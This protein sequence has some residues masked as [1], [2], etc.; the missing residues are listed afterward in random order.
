MKTK[1][2]LLLLALQ[3]ACMS[4]AALPTVP[5]D[6]ELKRA[7]AAPLS[8]PSVGVTAENTP[9]SETVIV[10]GSVNVRTGP[11]PTGAVVRWLVAG[12]EVTVLE[13][14]GEW[15]RIGVG[16]WVVRRELCDGGE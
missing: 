16:E 13:R 15:V 10:C 5:T 1:I 14:D 11:A 6:G 12:D 8:A 7:P 4:A 2:I 3:L 9:V